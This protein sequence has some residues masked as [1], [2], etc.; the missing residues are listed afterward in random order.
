M[1]RRDFLWR[2]SQVLT[3][4]GLGQTVLAPIL[5]S[6]T[7]AWADV[8]G[9]TP[10]KRALLIGINQYPDSGLKGCLTDLDLQRQ[11]LIYRLGF[12]PE[13]IVTLVD[14][15][16]TSDAIA[17]AIQDHLGHQ[18]NGNTIAW[19]HFSGLGCLGKTGQPTL[20]TANRGEL[21]LE[22]FAQWLSA[23]PTDKITTILDTSFQSSGEGVQGNVRLRSR[24]PLVTANWPE[25]EAIPSPALPTFPG[26]LLTATRAIP[27]S[28]VLSGQSAL[29]GATELD[30]ATWSAGRFTYG[31]TQALWQ[32]APSTPFPTLWAMTLAAMQPQLPDWTG[33]KLKEKA[34]GHP[35]SLTNPGAIGV[36]TAVNRETG[37][38][39]TWLGGLPSM[40][41]DPLMPRSLFSVQS[42][43]GLV[44]QVQVLERTGL[45]AK[46][47]F[48][49]AA[50]PSQPMPLAAGQ[51][52]QES[53]RVLPR[54][55]ELTIALDQHLTKVERVDAVSALSNFPYLTAINAGEGAA[56]CLLA[57]VDEPA[58]QVALLPNA[59]L[60]ELVLPVGYGLFTP[61]QA[62]IP[63][64][65]GDRGEAV[66]LAIKRLS[67]T[68]QTLLAKKILR[69]TEN[70]TASQLALRATLD[71]V[72]P[73]TKP[74]IQQT[75]QAIQATTIEP[76]D[77]PTVP[78][79]SHLQYH[80]QNLGSQTLYWLLL[81]WDS[82]RNSYLILPPLNS[83]FAEIAPGLTQPLMSSPANPEW[84][85]RN[86][87]GMAEAFLISSTAPFTR[88][89]TCVSSDP[90]NF[91]Q[92]LD[93]PLEIVQAILQDLQAASPTT[94]NLN[95]T[96]AVALNHQTWATLRFTYHVA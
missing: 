10:L 46:V 42:A 57:K 39:E 78:A 85:V 93:R 33:S 55:L 89:Q 75:T 52:L 73:K 67:P 72:S 19:I 61:T 80:L 1:K 22:Q 82:R 50:M 45:R 95:P 7:P 88:T 66:K 71:L 26:L 15:A 56:D 74:L 2:S 91:L 31:L 12:P 17:A 8:I 16:A 37:L 13:N 41:L 29:Q 58:T 36:I 48:V 20:L 70:I 84:I 53:I 68:L 43:A 30:F 63:H 54:Q 96:E 76:L 47:R 79:G 62:P 25:T 34:A 92:A 28:T 11:L 90:D 4:V 40:V 81:G 23:L 60:S 32:S 27:P 24:P 69:S 51:W 38:G 65:Q 77:S 83:N 87:T 94:Q 59:P 21:P 18:A 64:T 5:W 49:E 3:G 44:G 9:P 6:P 35:F 14:N 86:T